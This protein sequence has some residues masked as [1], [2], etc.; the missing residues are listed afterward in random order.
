MNRKFLKIDKTQIKLQTILLKEIK[1]KGYKK[2]KF[3]AKYKTNHQ[4]W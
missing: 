2:I 4:S 3:L 1:L